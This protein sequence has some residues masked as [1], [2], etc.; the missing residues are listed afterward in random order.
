MSG[1]II[2]SKQNKTNQLAS[3]VTQI[4]RGYSPGKKR[5]AKTAGDANLR[6]NTR[7]AVLMSDCCCG[8]PVN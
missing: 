8:C 2:V 4:K 3:S 5:T 1:R 6:N 7:A